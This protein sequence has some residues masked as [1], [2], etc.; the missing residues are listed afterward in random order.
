MAK[1]QKLIVI[2]N[3]IAGISLALKLNELSKDYSITVISGESDYHYSRPALMYIYMGHMREQDTIPYPKSFWRKQKNISLVRAWVTKVDS[4]AK[5]VAL[6]SGKTLEF[7]KL[8]FATGSKSNKFGWPGQDLQ[9]VQGLYSLQ[10][11]SLLEGNSRGAKN[12]VIVGGG[13]IGIEL[14]EMLHIRGIHVT[15]LVREESYWNNVLPKEESALINE[16]IRAENIDL[17]LKTNL[18]EI[19]DDGTGWVRSVI[20]EFDEEIPCDIVGLTA[21]VSPNK[22]LAEESGVE[23]GRG[24][25]ADPFFE[26]NIDDVFAIGDCAEIVFPSDSEEEEPKSKVDQLW[27]TGK[28]QGEQLA[29]MLATGSLVPYSKPLFYNSA[30]FL[31][32][33]YQVY[34]DVFPGREGEGHLYWEAKNKK[35]SLRIVYNK[36]TRKFVGVNLMGIRYRQKECH[37]W[38]ENEFTVEQVLKRLPEANFDPEFY[39]RYESEIVA[40]LKAQYS[41]AD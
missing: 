11:L 26:T 40:E 13:L 18:K 17:K 5:T 8:V 28:M 19:V 38:L 3:G 36:D 34:G 21:G 14:A 16:I 23:C 20:T 27:Y 37:S 41:S 12:A 24:I 10:D 32:L 15:F 9:G 1:K 25:K 31:D 33:E 22:K 4:K 29:A 7:D 30:K 35:H 6:D 2:G 39:K